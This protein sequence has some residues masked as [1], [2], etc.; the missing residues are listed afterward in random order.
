MPLGDRTG[1]LGM[2]PMTGRG[3][4]YCAGYGVPGYMNPIPGRGFFDRGRGRGWFGRGM[5]RGWGRG[6]GMGYFAG[7]FPGWGYY[8]AQVNPYAPDL[9]PE[10]EATLLKEDAEVLKQQLKELQ[11]YIDTLEKAKSQEKK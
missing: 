6:W 1:P 8:G 3:A 9:T 5:G 2:G 4:G 7:G 10:Q 11:G